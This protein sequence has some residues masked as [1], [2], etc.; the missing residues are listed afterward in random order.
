MLTDLNEE[1]GF[2]IVNELGE[3][4]IFIKQDVTN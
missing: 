3:N 1:H 2:N 4:A